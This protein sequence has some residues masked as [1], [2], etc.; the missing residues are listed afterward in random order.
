MTDR[1]PGMPQG[2]TSEETEYVYYVEV[3]GLP[4]RKAASMSG[5]EYR[6]INAPHVMQAREQV[7]HEVR[8][9]LQV[10]KEDVTFGLRD[11]INR[12]KILADPMTE[13]AGWNSII[14]LHG[15]DAPTRVTVSFKESVEA[16]KEH[17]R[18]LS[19]SEL[20]AE[21]GAGNIIDADFYEVSTTP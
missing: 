3:V 15:L 4:P 6:R 20:V 12:A 11:A 2:L 7:K 16:Y 9:D 10:T 13:I 14:K 18:R 17:V 19:D 21:I 5:M 8:G 1:L